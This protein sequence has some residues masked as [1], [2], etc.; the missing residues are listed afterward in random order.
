MI[1]EPGRLDPVR[2]RAALAVLAVVLTPLAL[3]AL[4]RLRPRFDAVW[5]N[6][7]AHFWLVLGAAAVATWLGYAV[8]TAARRRRDA[9]LLMVSLAFIGAAGFLG[10]HALATPG[11]LMGPNAGFE[12]ATPLGLLLGGIL[13]AVSAVEF[14]PVA[15]HRI[16]VRAQHFLVG[17]AALIALWAAVSLREVPPL[18]DPLQQEALQG[19]QLSFVAVGLLA[20]GVAA[21]GYLRLYRRR[22]VRFLF[23]LLI[24]LTLL[25][26]SM[27]V[28]AYAANW[29]VSWWEWHVLMLAA[30]GTIAVA[31]RAEWHEERFSPLYLEQTLAGAK[32]VS[33]LF[34]DL[35]GYTT[36]SE[37]APPGEVARML[38]AYFSRLIPLI[39]QMGGQVHQL[40]GDAIMVVFNK[41]GEQPDH[42]VAA[43]RSGLA[44]QEAAA[45]VARD[46]PQWPRFRVG[47]NS[48]EVATGI[49]GGARGHRKHD[50]IG[51][52]VNLAAR[53]EGQAPVGEVVIGAGT[54]DRLPS[55]TLV[56]RL[57]ALQVKGRDEPVTAYV[58]HG[59]DTTA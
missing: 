26:E 34:A 7:P 13:M 14:S 28:I 17:M 39:E 57:P 5:E 45:D 8:A 9:R 4:V 35:Q 20:Y 16:V 18:D 22:R 25:A 50:V 56:E 47:V 43:A 51:D 6:H 30:F 46:H 29:R 10:L 11:V 38:N 40:I 24:A 41:D 21:V 23:A 55:G 1:E 19:W 58:L 12:L 52:T 15:S 36:Y 44:L 3:L 27:V 31:A 32:D 37:P 49:L 2:R 42:A 33:V 48:G 59:L 53:L 54:Y